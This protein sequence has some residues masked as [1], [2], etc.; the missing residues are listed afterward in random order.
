MVAMIRVFD[1]AASSS[2]RSRS[3]ARG[4]G[5]FRS[6]SL[7][8]AQQV[9]RWDSCSHFFSAAAEAMR[10][11]LIESAR[12]KNRLRRGGDQLRLAA[13]ALDVAAVAA[14]DPDLLLDADSGLSRL[15]LEDPEAAELAK[16]RLFAGLSVGEAG[17]MLR[18]SCTVAYRNWE[19]VRAWFG[20]HCGQ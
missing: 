12:S 10:R 20:V 8:D 2:W 18:M 19:Y 9:K 6:G 3:S 1:R 5:Q 17:E 16:L 11:I 13:D 4:V 14:D 7:H 15:A